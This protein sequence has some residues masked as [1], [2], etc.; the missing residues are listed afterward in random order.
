MVGDDH[1]MAGRVAQAG[2]EADRLQVV[3]QPFAGL[4][5]LGCIGRV[6]RDRPD[7]QQREQALEAGVEILV[8][9]VED[10]GETG[11]GRLSLRFCAKPRGFCARNEALVD[12]MSHYGVF[13]RERFADLKTLLKD[14]D[15]EPGTNKAP[16]TGHRC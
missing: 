14:I 2:V 6:G 5:A 16:D 11:H 13:W 12:W 7:A 9:A 1:R 8:E 3:D 4:A 15:H 10:R